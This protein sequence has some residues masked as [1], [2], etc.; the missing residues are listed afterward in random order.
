MRA[1]YCC[2]SCVIIKL[3]KRI[4][5]AKSNGNLRLHQP[6]SSSGAHHPSYFCTMIRMVDTAQLLWYIINGAVARDLIAATRN[7]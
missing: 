1:C 3:I 7:G 5:E 2:Y 4:I 6:P